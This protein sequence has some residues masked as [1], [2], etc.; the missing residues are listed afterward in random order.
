VVTVRHRLMSYLEIRPSGLRF[1]RGINCVIVQVTSSLTIAYLIYVSIEIDQ[2]K[3]RY[4][5]GCWLEGFSHPIGNRMEFPRAEALEREEFWC[6]IGI[7]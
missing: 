5:L 7:I 3:I 1:P 6:W 2:T 4:C